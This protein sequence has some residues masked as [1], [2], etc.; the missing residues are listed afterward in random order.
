MSDR[1]EC[2]CGRSP[3][4]YCDGYHKMCNEEYKKFCAEQALKEQ[5]KPQLLND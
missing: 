1:K 3:D 2:R 4:G 5:A